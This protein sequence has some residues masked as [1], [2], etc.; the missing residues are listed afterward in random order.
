LSILVNFPHLLVLNKAFFRV[1][2]Q[3]V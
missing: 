2:N 3:L 1:S